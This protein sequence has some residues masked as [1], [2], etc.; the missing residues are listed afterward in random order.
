MQGD[1]V[2]MHD[3]VSPYE[4]QKFRIA[5]HAKIADCGSKIAVDPFC[6]FFVH[7]KYIKHDRGYKGI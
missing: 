1:H 6:K 4:W 3:H 7:K 2:N 5:I